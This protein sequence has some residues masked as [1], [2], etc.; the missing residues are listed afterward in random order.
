MMC[1]IFDAEFQ[2]SKVI[3]E[4]SPN[5]VKNVVKFQNLV[6]GTLYEYT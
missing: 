1:L 4:G 2:H 3:Q 5:P 6:E